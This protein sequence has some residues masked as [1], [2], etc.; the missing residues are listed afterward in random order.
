[1]CLVFKSEIQDG[2]FV[3]S[4]MAEDGP[5]FARIV[6]AVVAEEYNFAAEFGLKPARGLDLGDEET[7]RKKPARLL[8]KTN[9]GRGTHAGRGAGVDLSII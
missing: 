3:S 1:M 7:F 9:D 2:G 5:G 8:S 6:I 4:A